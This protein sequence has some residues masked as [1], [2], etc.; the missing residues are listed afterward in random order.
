MIAS[1]LQSAPGFGPGG[2][3]RQLCCNRAQASHDLR[4][5]SDERATLVDRKTLADTKAECTNVAD[6]PYAPAV[7]GGAERLSS[8]LNDANARGRRG[9][10]GTHTVNIAEMAAVMRRQHRERLP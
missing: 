5:N 8:I 2:M 1:K 7:L 10:H 4:V 6:D 3:R 9:Y